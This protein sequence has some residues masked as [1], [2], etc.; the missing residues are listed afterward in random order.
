MCEII[1]AW[2]T[3]SAQAQQLYG[4]VT[5]ENLSANA[6]NLEKRLRMVIDRAGAHIEQ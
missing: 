6:R 2:Q 1:K 4:E 3:A 5:A